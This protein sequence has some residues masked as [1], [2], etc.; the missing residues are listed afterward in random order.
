MIR[1]VYNVNQAKDI[2]YR[3]PK[4]DPNRYFTDERGAKRISPE[5]LVQLFSKRYPGVSL[6]VVREQLDSI[7]SQLDWMPGRYQS[8]PEGA[9]YRRH[10]IVKMYNAGQ[11]T[12][13]RLNQALSEYFATH[14]K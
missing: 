8:S 7:E 11:Q 9:E 1:T 14:S 2:L 10:T 13:E 5:G 3:L 4:V 6:Q 12:V